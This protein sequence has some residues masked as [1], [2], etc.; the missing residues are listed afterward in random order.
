MKK[1]VSLL[2]AMLLCLTLLPM[3][4]ADNEEEEPVL[5]GYTHKDAMEFI[6][7]M[8]WE[9]FS[10]NI[11]EANAVLWLPSFMTRLELT[12][13]MTEAGVLKV[14]AA[15]GFI[16]QISLANYGDETLEDYLAA[17]PEEGGLNG[18]IE[19]VNDCDWLIYDREL[20]D[21]AICRIAAGKLPDG[22]FLE[23]VYLAGSEEMD[24]MIEASIAT[25]RFREN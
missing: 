14:Y 22:A 16:V 18:R 1:L 11:K 20:E 23:V 7:E 10:T 24:S 6:G 15:E 4:Q 8:K 13:E 5:G 12:E 19:Q 3:A 21:A 9:G 17:V 25:L 2:L